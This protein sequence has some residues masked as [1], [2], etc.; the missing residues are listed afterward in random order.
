RGPV[1]DVDRDR[2]GPPGCRA[3][4]LA[5][6][7]AEPLRPVLP[8]RHDPEVRDDRPR[9]VLEGARRLRGAHPDR[10]RARLNSSHVKSSSGLLGIPG[11][12]RVAVFRSTTLVGS[13][14]VRSWTWSSFVAGLLA[15]A[16]VVWLALAPSLYARSFR[17]DMIPWVV[18][19]GLAQCWNLLAG[20]AGLI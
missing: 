9:P 12:A 14:A 17:N 18:M 4:R 10:K 13:Y 11:A 6:A 8:D 5:R 16:L 1:L 15:V 3:R 7:R 20:Y 2:G 19:I